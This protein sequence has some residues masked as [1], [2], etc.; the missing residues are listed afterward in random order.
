MTT[1]AWLLQRQGSLNKSVKEFQIL[2][3]SIN[4]FTYLSSFKELAQTLKSVS[5]HQ[6]NKVLVTSVAFFLCVWHVKFKDCIQFEQSVVK[7][8]P[9]ISIYFKKAY[10]QVLLMH[11]C[12]NCLCSCSPLIQHC[13]R[14]SLL[15]SQ[16][17][18][19]LTC[20]LNHQDIFDFV[21]LKFTVSARRSK[22]TN[23]QT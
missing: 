15:S 6:F 14:S 4:S 20:T 8:L 10:K 21:H 22:P 18:S 11:S 9:S 16:L 2:L 5:E 12:M 23:Q 3:L 19:W 13:N 1:S 17:F 7:K